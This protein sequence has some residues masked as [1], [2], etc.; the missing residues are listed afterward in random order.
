MASAILDILIT[1]DNSKAKRAFTDTAGSIGKLDDKIGKA[2]KSMDSLRG[3]MNK[4]LKIAGIGAVAGLGA[5]TVA[6]AGAVRV[7]SS[8]IAEG[9]EVEEMMGKYNVVF[10]DSAGTTDELTSS[11]DDFARLV[12]RNK[13]DLRGYATAFG[14]TFKPLGFATDEAADL[15]DTMTKLTVDLASFNNMSEDEVAQRLLGALIGGHENVMK[16]GVVINEATLKQE[17]MRLGMEDL[18]GAALEQAKVQARMNLIIAGVTDAQGDALR[19]SGSWAN[20]MRKLKAIFK[21]TR[22]EM[23]TK[24]L[25][26]FTPILEE[27]AELAQTHLPA[28]TDA[29]AAWVGSVDIDNLKLKMEGFFTGL[30]TAIENLSTGEFEFDLPKMFGLDTEGLLSIPI[31]F[32]LGEGREGKWTFG[33]MLP[34]DENGDLPVKLRFSDIEDTFGDLLLKDKSGVVPVKVH[35]LNKANHGLGDLMGLNESGEFPLTITM[36]AGPGG[37]FPTGI[38]KMLGADD[39]GK[40]TFDLDFTMQNDEKIAWGEVFSFERNVRLGT[41]DTLINWGEVFSFSRTAKLGFSITRIKWGDLFEADIF[42]GGEGGSGIQRL[43]I[44]GF[45][46]AQQIGI[47]DMVN[48]STWK[49]PDDPLGEWTWPD[50]PMDAW[51]WPIS[52]MSKWTWPEIKAPGWLDRLIIRFAGGTPDPDPGA[53]AGPPPDPSYNPIPDGGQLPPGD[54]IGPGSGGYGRVAGVGTRIASAI[55]TPSINIY[56]NVNNDLD[57]ERLGVQLQRHVRIAGAMA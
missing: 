46:I 5:F 9:S 33:D 55:Q 47:E 1:A 53:G 56:A 3:N 39:D 27:V 54:P 51:T 19:T 13:Y 12:G 25:P 20:Q 31:K 37:V 43:K 30:T 41:S 22:Q 32:T 38:K 11:L 24:L 42:G 17:L 28:L 2:S 21:E 50:D 7:A 23:G 10:A 15:S 16:F 57:V 8:L 4:G 49:W 40:L 44:G 6:A 45:E 48:V 26:I 18:T 35:F 29:F 52:P 34:V 14:D 36:G